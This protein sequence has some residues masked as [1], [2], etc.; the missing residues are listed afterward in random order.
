MLNSSIP[1]H[2][3]QNTSSLPANMDPSHFHMNHPSSQFAPMNHPSSQFAPNLQYNPYHI[4]PFLAQPRSHQFIPAP[5]SYQGVH[6]QGNFG[7]YSHGA[8]G[9]C[10]SNNPAS[11]VASMA[12]LGH[13]GG[14]GSRDGENSP[15]AGS[16]TPISAP[17]GV[18]AP[19][20]CEEGS[21]SSPDESVRKGKN[22]NWSEKED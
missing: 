20:Q 11:P 6:Y 5:S 2:D 1:S 7:Q 8:Y 16:G 3:P 9:G 15:V 17:H 21:E 19:S 14:S 18:E 22:K 12:Y 4:N 10:A 13:V